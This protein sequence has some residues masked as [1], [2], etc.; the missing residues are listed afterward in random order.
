MNS[1]KWW[2]DSLFDLRFRIY[3]QPYSFGDRL[4]FGDTT[5]VPPSFLSYYY[6]IDNY[7]DSNPFGEFE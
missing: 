7:H 1:F 4:C 2:V 5:E 3:V 6:R